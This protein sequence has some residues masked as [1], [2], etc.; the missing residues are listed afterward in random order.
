MGISPSNSPRSANYS[1][2]LQDESGG[3]TLLNRYLCDKYDKQH[4]LLPALGGDKRYQVLQWVHASEATYAL[5][6]LAI[7]YARWFQQGGDV[8]ATEKSLSVNVQ[9]DLD[10]LESE[11]GKSS[12]K[13]LFG[14]LITAADC[15]ME[16][17]LDFLTA[18]ELGTK[19]GSWPKV[20]EYLKVCHGTPT[21]K[22]AADKTGHKL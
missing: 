21:W 16:F 19:G 10:Y 13:F 7:L 1:A 11:L 14:D 9:K 22:K 18:R 5:H 17:T 8:E 2:V 6:G 4:R 15:M 12:G 3:L 20:Q